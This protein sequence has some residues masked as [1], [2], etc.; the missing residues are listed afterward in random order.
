M[1][2][3]LN[4]V[5]IKQTK[6]SKGQKNKKHPSETKGRTQEGDETIIPWDCRVN[7]LKKTFMKSVSKNSG[8]PIQ[9]ETQEN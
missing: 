3:D 7:A 4:N 1:P 6:K 8:T 2:L 5:L 9:E